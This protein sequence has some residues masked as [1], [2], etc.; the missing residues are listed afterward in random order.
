MLTALAC[1]ILSTRL[2]SPPD[3]RQGSGQVPSSFTT[4]QNHKPSDADQL[5]SGQA[6]TLRGMKYVSG[7][8]LPKLAILVVYVVPENMEWILQLHL[9]S[10]EQLTRDV[11]C[12]IIGVPLRL[13]DLARAI[14]ERRPMVDLLACEDA[15]E[16]SSKEHSLHL[17]RLAAY[18]CSKDFSH[19]A[20]FDVDSFPI[21]PGWF[22]SLAAQLSEQ[23]P[24]AAVLREEN[25][26][27]I[28]PHPSGL[29]CEMPFYRKHRPVFYPDPK[30]DAETKTLIAQTFQRPDTGIG[31]A[32]KAHALGLDWIALRRTNAVNDHYIMAGIYGGVFFHL[33]AMGRKPRFYGDST[34][35]P[36]R[37]QLTMTR[38]HLKDTE[39]WRA[40]WDLEN[41]QIEKENDT[42]QENILQK[43]RRDP[44]GYI[45]KLSGEAAPDVQLG[46]CVV[47]Q[48]RSVVTP[49]RLCR[50][51]AVDNRPIRIA[52]IVP[53]ITKGR[54][55]TEN[56]GQMMANAMAARG[57]HVE[58]FTFDDERRPPRF[59]LAPSIALTH[60][61]EAASPEN[62]QQFCTEVARMAPDL[63]VG[64]HM[65]RTFIRYARVAGR[66]GL[67]LVLSEHSDP[68]FPKRL[69]T[70]DTHE[71][72][73]S[74]SAAT[75]IHL[76]V[77]NFVETLPDHLRD[78]VRVIP[79]T[80]GPIAGRAE[81]GRSEGRKTLL[82]VARLVP[83]KQ[84]ARLVDAF[85]AI[86][87]DM[88]D[89]DLEIVGDGPE[90]AALQS[91]ACAAGVAHRIRFVGHV[92]DPGPYYQAAQL[93]TLPS[94]FEAFPMS[95]L[96]AMAYGLPVV[97]FRTCN[98]VNVQVEHHVPGLLSSDGLGGGTYH[99]DL[100]LLMGDDAA[101]DRLGRASLARTV[102]LFAP[103]VIEDA[104][105]ALFREAV[106][107]GPRIT[108]PSLAAY[109]ASRLDDLIW[110]D[111]AC[112]SVR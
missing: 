90:M 19:F 42:A 16:R 106:K 80:A 99:K 111:G 104:W 11:D 83:R 64:L 94:K 109:T 112:L 21:R 39:W 87:E 51:S 23:T 73:V 3:E 95:T 52:M 105:E 26:D 29:L 37:A 20:T 48:P 74:F 91:K 17:D 67:P 85:S 34:T 31:F 5:F 7:V 8:T 25:R 6:L 68:R 75:L 63:I 60:L 41:K 70:F 55:G 84:I 46:A 33:G 110:G 65:N 97:G 78:R 77:D 76:L 108:R 13:S 18:A 27:F 92:D 81:P 32:A 103:S 45:R 98:G 9:D 100:A 88:A 69:G 35:T 57:H 71:R 4:G 53:W 102:A 61:G 50:T 54:G 107:L 49:D 101:R 36:R 24:F 14:L 96:E 38:R 44:P 72:I 22:T 2:Q 79:N 15:A 30:T 82:S 56:V 86:A 62:D 10:I 28:L 43:L 89:W 1:A 59:D 40:Q 58:V 93:F 12:R 47:D 66:L